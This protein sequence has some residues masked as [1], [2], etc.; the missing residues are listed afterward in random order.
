MKVKAVPRICSAVLQTRP[1][2]RTLHPA[3]S[4]PTQLSGVETKC[5]YAQVQ[6]GARMVRMSQGG[7]L[8]A[9][10][11]LSIPHSAIGR[12]S[13]CKSAQE[14]KRQPSKQCLFWSRSAPSLCCLCPGLGGHA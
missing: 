11:A 13:R 8:A 6:Q 3:P 5:Q 12:L 1:A 14:Y 4:L 2:T 9:S 7:A 10:V